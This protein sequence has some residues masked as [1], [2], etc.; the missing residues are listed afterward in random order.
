MISLITNILKCKKRYGIFLAILILCFVIMLVLV[1]TRKY[2]QDVLENGLGTEIS[3]R[4]LM[5]INT[6]EDT[7]DCIKASPNITDYY[8]Y[9]YLNGSLDKLNLNLNLSYATTYEYK[10]LQGKEIRLKNEIIVP[11]ELSN[12]L[13]GFIH[14]QI[15]QVEYILK[16][17]GVSD[18]KNIVISRGLL[19]ELLI[20]NN[21]NI[22]YYVLIADNYKY[23]QKNIDYFSEK[24]YIAT[25]ENSNGVS[26]YNKM[27]SFI[28]MLE[29]FI[30]A[31]IGFNFI[32]IIY[33]IKNIFHIESK[34]MAI[35]KA[36]G[37]S[38]GNISFLIL[39]KI[40]ILLLISMVLS[41]LIFVII[42][43]LLS[44]ILLSDY[45]LFSKKCWFLSNY[46]FLCLGSIVLLIINYIPIFFKIK[47]VDVVKILNGE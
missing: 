32:F 23:A 20:H 6:E 21:L 2:Y 34:D 4:K 27:Q 36:I 5:V 45:I 10:L 39:L 14:V 25:L 15:N 46:L 3:N 47:N 16:V 41:V 40:L 43:Y 9:T 37:Y 29:K 33:I 11:K 24:G 31:I 12:Y 35:L 19:D 13:N 38:D 28:S 44:F 7:L 1:N 26:E 18:L 17:V 42:I 8:P 22:G 30:Y